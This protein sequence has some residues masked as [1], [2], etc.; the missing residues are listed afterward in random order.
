MNSRRRWTGSSKSQPS[1]YWLLTAAAVALQHKNLSEAA[2]DLG[3]ARD[4]LGAVTFNE[5]LNDYFFRAY[6]DRKELADFF[7]LDPAARR[8]QLE[9]TMTYTV[10]P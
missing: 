1:G 3:R 6:A 7:P 10:E 9:P 2:T 8:A 4:A 5:L